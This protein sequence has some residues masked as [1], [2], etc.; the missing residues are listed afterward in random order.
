MATSIK[1][2]FI[3]L[4]KTVLRIGAST[5]PDVVAA[6][7]PPLGV[8][9]RSVLSSVAITESQASATSGLTKKEL[10]LLGVQAGIPALE[11][12]FSSAGKPIVNP[13]L[14]AS[15]IE[16]IQ[17]G[18]VDILNATGDLAKPV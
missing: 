10:A 9:L 12:A 1:S 14:F 8:L 13:E 15:G 4:G 7:N 11:I 16:K 3:W 5:V 6:Y 2:F 17:D 18:V